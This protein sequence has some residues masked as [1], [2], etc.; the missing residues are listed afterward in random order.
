MTVY[1]IHRLMQSN[2]LNAVPHRKSRGAKNQ[3][4]N[5]KKKL[6]ETS[7]A[8]CTARETTENCQS[9]EMQL[10]IIRHTH[11]RSYASVVISMT[12]TL[13]SIDK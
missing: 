10:K 1:L 6:K 7:N 8:D 5:R 4:R 2:L 3:N 13:L 9:G 11:I 12:L